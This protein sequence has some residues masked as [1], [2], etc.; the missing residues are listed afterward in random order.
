MSVAGDDLV[1]GEDLEKVVEQVEV[2]AAFLGVRPRFV[3]VQGQ[4]QRDRNAVHGVAGHVRAERAARG[5]SAA[6]HRAVRCHL[7]ARDGNTQ[8]PK[9]LVDRERDG[10]FET[11]GRQDLA[12]VPRFHEPAHDGAEAVCDAGGRVADAMVVDEQEAHTADDTLENGA[13]GAACSADAPARSITYSSGS[14]PAPPRS[15]MGRSTWRVFSSLMAGSVVAGTMAGLR[16]YVL[17]ALV[18]DPGWD[19]A[20]QTS[21]P[22]PPTASPGGRRPRARGWLNH[23]RAAPLCP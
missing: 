6:L 22:F 2:V 8:S 18:G 20:L 5:M 14:S 11:C 1:G 10:A 7:R 3:V 17:D 19:A 16:R 9:V 4:E 15:R 23:P 12:V 13:A 21:S